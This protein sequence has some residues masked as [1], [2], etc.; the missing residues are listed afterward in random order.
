MIADETTNCKV[1]GFPSTNVMSVWS[2]NMTCRG[3]PQNGQA[4][5]SNPFGFFIGSKGLD[6]SLVHRLQM[7]FGLRFSISISFAFVRW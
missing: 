6:D 2:S 7:Y 5:E 1:R 4:N 3:I